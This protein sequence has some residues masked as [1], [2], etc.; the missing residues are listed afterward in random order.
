VLIQ[1]E[2]DSVR[3]KESLAEGRK[4]AY[5]T[6]FFLDTGG[7]RVKEITPEIVISSGGAPT[8]DQSLS[9]E[10]FIDVPNKLYTI[11]CVTADVGEVNGFA[12]SVFSDN[13]RG[14]EFK[15]FADNAV[16]GAVA[17]AGAAPGAKG[18][19]K[20]RQQEQA[21]KLLADSSTVV[22]MDAGVARAETKGDFKGAE[23]KASSRAPAAAA[24]TN[25][26][27]AADGGAG[28]GL[29]RAV[30]AAPAAA[31]AVPA[32]AAAAPGVI[33]LTSYVPPKDDVELEL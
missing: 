18:E 5:M 1:L 25:Q 16:Y 12:L 10:I 15:P 23:A 8:N 3:D 7:K 32:A 30:V 17:G 26:T 2:Q 28:V 20:K 21:T 29:P 14:F 33:V 13:E 27:T 11:V 22:V 4:L 31:V 24:A 19:D 9:A 6:F